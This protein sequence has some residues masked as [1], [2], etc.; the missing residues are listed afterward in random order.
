M[1][2]LRPE[3]WSAPLLF[4]MSA[5]FC[6]TAVIACHAAQSGAGGNSAEPG[7]LTPSYLRCEN[8]E[9][10][11]GMDV[12]APRLSWIVESLKRG[13]KQ[14]AYRILVAGSEANLG[15]D[16]GDLWDSGRV[17]GDETTGIEYAGQPLRSHQAC[18]WKVRVWDKEG[19]PSTWSQPAFWS[20]GMVEPT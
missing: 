19:L 17:A 3:S 20:M 16:Q 9:T 14:T 12:P 5:S 8:R 2:V 18:F 11:L 15:R 1:L 13:Q 10:P 7:G 4:L 6:F